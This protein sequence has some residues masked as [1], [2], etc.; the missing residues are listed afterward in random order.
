MNQE[1]R[2]YLKL[3]LSVLRFR[4][5]HNDCD[6]TPAIKQLRREVD[7][8]NKKID[9]FEKSVIAKKQAVSPIL[10]KEKNSAYEVIFGNDFDKA[11]QAVKDVEKKYEEAR[12][13]KYGSPAN[14]N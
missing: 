5:Y 13:R 14:S 6:D 4:E 8:R 7:I 3:R 12:A 2:K 9:A 10:E 1:Q 11:L